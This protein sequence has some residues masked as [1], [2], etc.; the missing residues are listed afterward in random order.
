M[1]ETTF[2]GGLVHE[3]VQDYIICHPLMTCESLYLNV[4]KYAG[5][6]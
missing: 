2:L 1:N 6:C 5:H 3:A 4:V